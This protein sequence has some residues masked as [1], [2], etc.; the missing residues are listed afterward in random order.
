MAFSS[1]RG[2]LASTGARTRCNIGDPVS[3]DGFVSRKIYCNCHRRRTPCELL[4][5]NSRSGPIS[6]SREKTSSK[7]PAEL[8][9]QRDASTDT[10]AVHFRS[11]VDGCISENWI[12][13]NAKVGL[14]ACWPAACVT[15]MRGIVAARNAGRQ[16]RFMRGFLAAGE[17]ANAEFASI[18]SLMRAHPH[19]GWSSSTCDE[20]F[21]I[22]RLR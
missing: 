16:N 3:L 5:R 17:K 22:G 14:H 11:S 13:A 7:D 1:W 19:G 18:R 15:Q 8:A 12:S 4:S 9:A 6:L 21:L 2:V 20:A 10:T